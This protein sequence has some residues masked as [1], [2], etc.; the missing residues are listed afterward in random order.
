MHCGK[1]HW[2]PKKH[3]GFVYL[4]CV[5]SRW[6]FALVRTQ[7]LCEHVEFESYNKR[8]VQFLQDFNVVWLLFAT[9]GVTLYWPLE[10]T[11]VSLSDPDTLLTLLYLPYLLSRRAMISLE[12]PMDFPDLDFHFLKELLYISGNLFIH[13]LVE[14]SMRRSTPLSNQSKMYNPDA[15]TR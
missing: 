15:K 7:V 9:T 3:L 11:Q 12:A 2:Q 1:A 6:R 10:R 14:G 5:R 13:R 8:Q 4:C